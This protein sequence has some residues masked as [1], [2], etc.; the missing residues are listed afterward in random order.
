MEAN[1]KSSAKNPTGIV[2][3][4]AVGLVVGAVYFA[5]ALDQLVRTE[6]L[7]RNHLIEITNAF[8]QT[9]AEMR[10]GDSPVPATFRRAGIEHF[11]DQAGLVDKNGVHATVRMPGIPGSEIQT[12]ETDP[13]VRAMIGQMAETGASSPVIE[14]HRFENGRLIGRTLM[15]SIA[16]HESCVDCH[17]AIFGE[18][19]FDTGD[20]MGAFVVQTDLTPAML[21]IV[22]FT[23]VA[24]AIAFAGGIL[25]SRRERRYANEAIAALEAR[26]QADQERREAE[27]QATYL[28]S[29]DAL[30]GLANRS[31][32]LHRITAMMQAH[33]FGDL[34]VALVDLNNFK[35]VN[36]TYGHAAGDK[37]LQEIARRIDAHAGQI[38]GMAARLAGDE[39]AMTF[40]VLDD[41]DA[42]EFCRAL[43]NSL[44]Q[45]VRMD[46]SDLRP[47]ASVGIAKWSDT[48]GDPDH[49]MQAADVALD[50]AK[51]M[52]DRDFCLFDNSL[53]ATMGRRAKLARDLPRA[54]ADGEVHPAFQ[55]LMELSTGRLVA[56]EALARWTWNGEF[57][58]PEE[59]VDIAE[60][61]QLI[62]DLDLT[63]LRQAAHFV[64][65][66]RRELGAD[67]SLS[68]NLSATN[69]RDPR[70]VDEI[71]AILQGAGLPFEALSLEITE[72]VFLD[73]WISGGEVLTQLQQ[74][75][76]RIA[77]DDFGT[78]FSALSYLTDF[79]F[80]TIKLDR[81]FIQKIDH[82]QST[83]T[84]SNH[85]VKLASS[86]EKTVV[87][88]GVET[89]EQVALM[90]DV[91][92]HI[93]QGYF[94][95]RP[96]NAPDATV[97]AEK[98]F[99]AVPAGRAARKSAS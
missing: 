8:T 51:G 73:N 54:I 42:D 38:D 62:R 68:S 95:A 87:V 47:R 53:K 30:T 74:K 41:F 76:A 92:A 89:E 40:M 7:E 12:I 29:H 28:A 39:F 70:L 98:N 90:R 19:R 35:S 13:R 79:P 49:L 48:G 31:D 72:K 44:A 93:G 91:G 26:V 50:A 86:L 21:E 75:G 77:L 1:L 20:V 14:E 88:E 59:F 3:A 71:D 45:A 36:D 60:A 46:G 16:N 33:H 55:P 65:D 27:A 56:F 84:V 24:F 85:I 22:L 2:A 64:A 58:S 78:G 43:V 25:L 17:N 15:P 94:F 10:G 63:I 80:D 83:L 23:G 61:N 32:F 66:L 67:I 81:S 97:F 6:R 37:L 52:Q 18:A 11:S 4:V 82:S 57:V 34:V 69:L 96:L 99:L 5:F 9:Y